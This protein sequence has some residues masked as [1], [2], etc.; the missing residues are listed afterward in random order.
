MEVVIGGTRQPGSEER[1]TGLSERLLRVLE[2]PQRKTAAPQMAGPQLTK[3]GSQLGEVSAKKNTEAD[4]RRGF[5]AELEGDGKK[6]FTA[7]ID[8]TF[9]M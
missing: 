8:T 6:L 9:G 4:N 3:K 2:A 7:T 1:L 5:S